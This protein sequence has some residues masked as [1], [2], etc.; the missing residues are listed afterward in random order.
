MAET[1]LPSSAK[2]GFLR[3]SADVIRHMGP[4]IMVYF[5]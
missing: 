1:V 5:G 4:E 3:V 2:F